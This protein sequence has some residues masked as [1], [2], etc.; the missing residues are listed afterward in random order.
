MHDERLCCIRKE[1][2][3]SLCQDI[4]YVLGFPQSLQANAKIVPPLGHDRFLPS[5]FQFVI[6]PFF[7]M[8]S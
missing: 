7:A 6:P 2:G 1:L 5:S 3:S 8:K 4:C